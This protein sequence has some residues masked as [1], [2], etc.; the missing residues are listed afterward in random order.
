[1]LVLERWVE[2]SVRGLG[3]DRVVA[4]LTGGHAKNWKKAD[5]LCMNMWRSRET[6]ELMT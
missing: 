6:D 3:L 5:S 1:M 2:G 4:E